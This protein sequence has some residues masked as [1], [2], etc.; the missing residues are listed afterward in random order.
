VK[1]WNLQKKRKN[2]RKKQKKK[3]R[4]EGKK[5]IECS[6]KACA[7]SE[8]LLGKNKIEKKLSHN[9]LSPEKK[10]EL[11]KHLDILKQQIFQLEKKV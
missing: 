3:K 2:K 11:E 10:K 5:M 8:L 9:N 7:L 4:K 1:V 6:K